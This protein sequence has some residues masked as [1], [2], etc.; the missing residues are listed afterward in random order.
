[1][2]K[3][4]LFSDPQSCKQPHKKYCQENLIWKNCE[5]V[6]QSGTCYLLITFT[7]NGAFSFIIFVLFHA[8]SL[9]KHTYFYHYHMSV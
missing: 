9:A 2:T 6:L 3:I 7:V 8:I 5:V 1:M 4:T